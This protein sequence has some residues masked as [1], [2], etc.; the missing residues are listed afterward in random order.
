MDILLFWQH[1]KLVEILNL[2]SSLEFKEEEKEKFNFVGCRVRGK[3]K[4]NRNSR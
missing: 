1:Y 3:Q 2:Q 4:E